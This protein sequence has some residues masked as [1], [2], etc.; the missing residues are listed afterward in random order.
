[1][2]YCGVVQLHASVIF[3]LVGDMF[4][5]ARDVCLVTWLVD[6]LL[7]YTDVYAYMLSQLLLRT[8]ANVCVH[9]CILPAVA[10]VY[11]YVLV[12]EY[13]SGKCYS[14]IFVTHTDHPFLCTFLNIA[15]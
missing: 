3:N 13:T 9:K 14:N 15:S 11:A 5:L 12:G 7:P 6:F 1:M 10:C 4:W 2:T 8:Q